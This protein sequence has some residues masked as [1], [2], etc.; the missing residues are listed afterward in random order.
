MHGSLRQWRRAATVL[1]AVG[2]AHPGPSPAAAAED[3]EILMLQRTQSSGF[4]PGAHVFPGGVLDTSDSSTD[5]LQVFKPYHGPPGFGLT[6]FGRPR[7]SYPEV[8]FESQTQ[9][10]SLIP[11]D[12]AHRICAIR[13]TFEES[14]VLLLHP[15]GAETLHLPRAFV[16]PDDLASW[17]TRVR[18]DPRQFLQLCQR[19]GCMPNIWALQEWS[20]WLT[21]FV[22]K[23][24][25]RY[26]TKF[27]ICCL[28]EKPQTFLDMIEA[29]KCEWL[30]PTEAIKKFEDEEIL[31]VPPQFYEIRRLTQFAFLSDLHKFCL[32]RI[33][34]G[35]ERWLPITLLTLDGIIQLLPEEEV[36][37]LMRT[38][39]STYALTS[40][41]SCLLQKSAI[42]VTS[43]PPDFHPSLSTSSWYVAF[44][45][46]QISLILKKT[47]KKKPSSFYPTILS[48]CHL[49]LL[50]TFT[51]QLGKN[52]LY[53]LTSP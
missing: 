5:W 8:P 13:E 6:S 47:N 27:Y 35:C 40:H 26:D 38:N 30:T 9:S 29:I 51:D 1:L 10:H 34:E 44:K 25:R 41:L 45:Y 3:Y 37:L 32:D 11:E 17:R 2:R 53:F 42:S 50:C 33:S 24:G 43:L 36:I 46:A 19:L 4:L 31:L 21:P 15:A 39:I 22:K 49:M 18:E 48:S 23:G 16:L 20:N 12:V 52:Y 7:E 28:Q 14:G